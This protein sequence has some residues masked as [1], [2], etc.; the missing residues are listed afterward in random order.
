MK[1]KI[2]FFIFIS[3]FLLIF[4]MSISSFNVHAEEYLSSVNGVL[5]DSEIE[6]MGDNP[7]GPTDGP[8]YNPVSDNDGEYHYQP[9]GSGEV[10]EESSDYLIDLDKVSDLYEEK[11]ISLSDYYIPDMGNSEYFDDF[12]GIDWTSAPSITT[13]D[14][15]KHVSPDSEYPYID[16]E[17]ADDDEDFTFTPDFDTAF[18][19][20]RYNDYLYF[21]FY[22]DGNEVISPQNIVGKYILFDIAGY[23]KLAIRYDMDS[24]TWDSSYTRLSNTHFQYSGHGYKTT[25]EVN[26]TTVLDDWVCFERFDNNDYLI[27]TNCFVYSYRNTNMQEDFSVNYDSY[28]DYF[29]MNSSLFNFY[30]KIRSFDTSDNKVIEIHPLK[31]INGAS[32]GGDDFSNH[33]YLP[34]GSVIESTY[35][36]ANDGDLLIYIVPDDAQKNLLNNY[37][38]RIYPTAHYTVTVSEK[39]NLGSSALQK[40]I[41]YYDLDSSTY[42]SAQFEC[43]YYGT[44]YFTVDFEDCANKLYKYHFNDINHDLKC[45]FLK[46]YDMANYISSKGEWNAFYKALSGVTLSLGSNAN[47]FTLD[48][49]ASVEKMGLKVDRCDYDFTVKVYNKNNEYESEGS[50]NHHCD[51]VTGESRNNVDTLTKTKKEV[52]DTTSSP[53]GKTDPDFNVTPPDDNTT[54]VTTS[55]DGATATATATANNNATNSASIDKDAVNINI[56][57]NSGGSSAPTE[58]TDSSLLHGGGVFQIISSL[59]G[60]NQS[61]PDEYIENTGVGG[62][63]QVLSS[64]YTFVPVELWTIILSAVACFFGITIIAFII[65]VV[66]D[67]L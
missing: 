21:Y 9:S 2:K 60:D 39:A 35:K 23:N 53:D 24:D 22:F 4:C 12:L 10:F 15:Y 54:T 50:L 48:C 19:C 67:L 3:S 51:L 31:D 30:K 55:G 25:K 5:F 29:D 38:V 33:T 26:D 40:V 64:V 16:F 11:D 65:R 14:Y 28:F 45:E 44:E 34:E 18:T 52:D 32:G 6:D 61:E 36:S 8:S 27:A 49:D 47:K 63:F 37:E 7:L 42:T 57:N 1:C 59:I 58:T 20:V 41:N 66:L 17:W 62:W 43:Q 56:E 13:D 46:M